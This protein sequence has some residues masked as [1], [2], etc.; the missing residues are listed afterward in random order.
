RRLALAEKAHDHQVRR[1]A[2]CG[3]QGVKLPRRVEQQIPA[4]QTQLPTA[5]YDVNFTL[6]N[7]NELPEVM[8]FDLETITARILKIVHRHDPVHADRALYLRGLER[9]CSPPLPLGPRLCARGLA[10]FHRAHALEPA[11]A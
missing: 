5:R 2:A 1:G 3:P 8:L 11:K 7:V 4:A 10:V 9:H 6:I